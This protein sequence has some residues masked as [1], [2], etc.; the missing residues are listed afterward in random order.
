[1]LLFL[2][3]VLSSTLQRPG[4][5]EV[6][7]KSELTIGKACVTRSVE[8][9][10][11]TPNL[12]VMRE[13]ELIAL[14]LNKPRLRGVSSLYGAMAILSAVPDLTFDKEGLLVKTRSPE[15]EVGVLWTRRS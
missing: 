13:L 14:M 15:P 12:L 7:S 5:V 8:T 3:L 9:V 11:R 2:L 6:S 10:L 1:M 4:C